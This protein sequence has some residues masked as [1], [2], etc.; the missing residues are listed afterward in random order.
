VLL[1]AAEGL[2]RL[3]SPIGP[4]L[5]VTDPGVGKHYVPGFRG[6]VF[7]DE[8]GR[9]VDVR[10]NSLGFRG[11]EW[12]ERGPAGG[13]R[14]AVLGDSMTAAIA[15]DEDRTFVRR[16]ETA[17]GSGGGL[18]PVE[19]MN[20]GVS[21]SSTGSE[22]VTWRK[23]VT[24]YRP[25]LVLL[26]FFT[27]NDFGDNSPRLTRAPRT[28]FELDGAGRLVQGPD[29]AP[30]PAL[31]RWLDHNS[32]LYVWQKAAFRKLRATAQN[33]A[34]GIEPSQLIFARGGDPDVEH[35]WR[36][37]A[38]LVLRLRDEAEA[39]GARCHP[40]LPHRRRRPPPARA[41]LRPAV[42]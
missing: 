38:A 42:V 15:T 30:T 35:A 37:T 33:A 9:H 1:L 5:L 34:R 28:Y 6:R 36:L 12:R 23:V 8:A 7:V 13:L 2:V 16:L 39:S 25:D 27:G 3:L 32:R 4:A 19:V 11:P 17:L 18:A 40:P 20:F 31:T 26:A 24:R 29:P 14:I 41:A 22:L 21:S 10:F